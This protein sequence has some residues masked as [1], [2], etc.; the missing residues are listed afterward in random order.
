MIGNS[1]KFRQKMERAVAALLSCRSVEEA[2]RAGI[3]RNTLKRWMKHP[4]FDTAYRETRAALLSQAVARLEAAADAAAK[5]V[6]KVMLSPNEPAGARLRAAENV[7][8]QAAKA[9]SIEDL[10]VRLRNLERNAGSKNNS[11][12]SATATDPIQSSEVDVV[13]AQGGRISVPEIAQRLQIGRM[14]VYSMLEQGILP[15]VRLGRR[16][17]VTR[18]AYLIWEETCGSRAGPGPPS[19][20][21]KNG[22]LP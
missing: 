4:E 22:V 18:R 21:G 15:G 9:S 8:E 17:I 14:A 11:R 6:L 2:A 16:W 19:L 13:Q 3:G 5:T 20:E 1:R 10:E 12:R 7:L